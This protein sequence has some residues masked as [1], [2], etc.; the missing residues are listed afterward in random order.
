MCMILS[1]SDAVGTVGAVGAVSAV[2]AVEYARGQ[3]PW[4]SKA[5]QTLGA[6][7]KPW[8]RAM[9]CRLRVRGERGA[10]DPNDASG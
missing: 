3:V 4:P 1:S 9:D 5:Q 7:A 10:G 6:R 2:G 8:G